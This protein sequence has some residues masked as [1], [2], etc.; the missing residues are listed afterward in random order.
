MRQ[1]ASDGNFT[2]RRRGLGIETMTALQILINLCKQFEGVRLTAYK[3][4]GG[5]W[6][7]GYGHTGGDV[8]PGP[9]W[10]QAEC[11]AVLIMD[12]QHA[13]NAALRVSP[14]LKGA[15]PGQQAAIGS[16]V[17]NLGVNGYVNHS[18]KPLVDAQKWQ[19]AA[20]EIK[21]FCQDA[22]KV[23]PGLVARRLAESNLLVG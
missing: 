12:A 16:L 17:Y 13:L 9:V 2:T 10:T 4:G 19:S 11:E 21:L 7:I 15:T 18:V 1:V 14:V 22:G 6:T 23:E 8:H 5:V 20:V 3:D